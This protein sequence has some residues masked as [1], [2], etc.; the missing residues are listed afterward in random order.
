[1][2][3]NNKPKLADYHQKLHPLGFNPPIFEV[4]ARNK[5]DVSLLLQALLYSLDPGLRQ[6]TTHSIT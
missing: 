1:M 3:L 5:R 4:D 2:D 6:K